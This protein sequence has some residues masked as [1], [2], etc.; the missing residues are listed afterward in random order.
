MKGYWFTRLEKD[1][2]RMSPHLHLKYVKLGFWRIYY[3]QA[4]VH[5]V[6]EEMPANG[7]DIES[8]DPRLESQSYF[9]EYEDNAELIRTIK[10]FVEGYYDSRQRLETRLYMLRNDME[11][12]KSATKAY[13]QATIK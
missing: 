13:Q 8:Y 10:N 7:Y 1:I 3:K 2:E 6:Y 9:E 5:E 4:Y 11:F 12:Y